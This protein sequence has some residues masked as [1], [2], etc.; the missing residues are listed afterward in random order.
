MTEERIFNYDTMKTKSVLFVILTMSV[1]FTACD[2]DHSVIPSG[3]VTTVN[4]TI[5]G[6]TKVNVSG[7]FSLYVTFSNTDEIIEI[8]ANENLHE[9][10]I[11][12]KQGDQLI[13]QLANNVSINGGNAVLNVYVTTKQ[14]DAFYGVGA[15]KIQLQNDLLGDNLL[16][17]LTG[18][19]NFK[20]FVQ[21]NQL[22]AK[23]TG[24]SIM[25][26]TGNSDL[27]N[28]E[29]TG[30][31]NLGGYDFETN[32][33]IADLDGA[34]NIYLTVQQSLDVTAAGA[35]N[36]Y[37]KG[38]GVITDQNLSGGSKIVKMD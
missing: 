8:E 38:S 22:S 10:I 36:V 14:L 27:F 17:E 12:E 31:S 37:Y 11:V 23:I 26:L 9:F 15:V 5:T 25:D 28:M 3:N 1:L 35:S 18:A 19:S 20:G 2:E 34:C 16:V 7:P 33:F 6:Y 21:V 4:K 30:A 24:A 32:D 13:I 29:A